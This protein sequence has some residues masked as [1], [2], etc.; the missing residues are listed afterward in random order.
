[1]VTR[2][3]G[4]T[5][6]ARP[7]QGQ[8]ALRSTNSKKVS[9][10]SRPSTSE[11]QHVVF[12]YSVQM[13]PAQFKSNISKIELSLGELLKYGGLEVKEAIRS[14]TAPTLMKPTKPELKE[15]G[16]KMQTKIIILKEM[17]IYKVEMLM[18]VKDKMQW[19]TNNRQIYMRYKQH[20]L[21][22]MEMK[23]ESMSA[24]KTIVSSQNGL[25]L[26][27]LLKKIL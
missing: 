21:P 5:M 20:T 11:M 12:N 26:I 8:G 10:P 14:G 7:K 17:E 6:T 18:N 4:L 25:D 1:M 15:V 23:L 16:G 22:A 24:Y 9:K 19:A 2:S 27:E 3:M 13:K